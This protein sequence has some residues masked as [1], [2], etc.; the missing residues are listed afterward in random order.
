MLLII[1]NL[2]FVGDTEAVIKKLSNRRFYVDFTT[3]DGTT[4][5]MEAA[6][7]GMFFSVN[8]IFKKVD[9]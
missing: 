8:V 2:E 4:M 1:F 9:N 6:A 5:L 7:S 3:P